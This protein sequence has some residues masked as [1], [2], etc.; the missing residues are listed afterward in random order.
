MTNIT[1]KVRYLVQ[2]EG[3]MLVN[4]KMINKMEKALNLILMVASM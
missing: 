2:M 3:C 1:D 4:G